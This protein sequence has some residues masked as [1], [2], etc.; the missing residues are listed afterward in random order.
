[1]NFWVVSVSNFATLTEEEER[2]LLRLSRLYW[3]EALRCEEA[4]AYVAGC[5]ML[6]SVLEAMLTL[7][8]NCYDD[9]AALTGHAPMKAG[10]IR[11]LL[12]W[13]LADLL[14]VAKAANWLPAGLALDDN[15]NSRLAKVGDYAEVIRMI[16]NLLHPARYAKDHFRGRVTKK[17]LQR[18]FE[19]LELCRGWLAHHNNESLLRHMKEKETAGS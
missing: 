13:S 6:G 12:D 3:K 19:F 4:G 5:V 15:W 17:Y 2:E 18:Q 16:R 1:M 7:M 11:P 10:R 8:V 9:Q 14:K